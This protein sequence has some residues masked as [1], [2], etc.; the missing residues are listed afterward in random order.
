MVQYIDLSLHFET[1][2]TYS[3]VNFRLRQFGNIIMEYIDV[4][5]VQS[6]RVTQNMC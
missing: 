4:M 3:I 2:S 5:Y 1:E 6:I